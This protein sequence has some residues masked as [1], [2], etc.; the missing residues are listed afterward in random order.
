MAQSLQDALDVFAASCDTEKERAK[1]VSKICSVHS[2][3]HQIV[4]AIAPGSKV[5]DPG[6]FFLDHYQPEIVA[7]E[8]ELRCGRITLPVQGYKSFS[9]N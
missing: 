4:S 3:N 9:E 8:A 7:D 1:L 2:A 5:N 6:A